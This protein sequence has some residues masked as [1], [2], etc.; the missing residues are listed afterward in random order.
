ME[1]V[2]ASVEVVEANWRCLSYCQMVVADFVVVVAV[3]KV[4]YQKMAYSGLSVEHQTDIL[5]VE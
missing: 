2:V 1:I 5:F 3:A 4:E